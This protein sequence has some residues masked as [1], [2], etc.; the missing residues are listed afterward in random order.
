MGKDGFNLAAGR[1]G[2]TE[3]G[4]AGSRAS[5]HGPLLACALAASLVLRVAFSFGYWTGKPLT[6]DEQE[7]LLLAESLAGGRGFHYPDPQEGAAAKRFERPPGFP[8]ALAAVLVGTRAAVPDSWLAGRELA[9]WLTQDSSSVPPSIRLGQA[10]LGSLVVLLIAGLARRAAGRVAGVAAAW[11][12]AVYPPLVWVCA[13]VLSEPLYSVLA[14]STALLLA[15]ATSNDVRR[16]RLVAFVAGLAAALAVLT[17]EAMLL[18]LPLAFIWLL[19]RRKLAL[20]ALLAA[21]AVCGLAPWA[22]RNFAADR[23]FRLSAARGGINFWIGN[24]PLA[25][26]EGDMAANPE[27]K[28]ASLALEAAHPGASPA[29]MD[30]VYYREAFDYIAREPVSW[31]KL[32]GRKLFYTVVPAGPS[33]TLRSP[34]YMYASVASYGLLFIAA[35]PGAAWL[36]RK[37]RG[38]WSLWILG[39]SAVLT[40]LVFFPQER[41]RIPVIDPVLIVCAS[42]WMAAWAERRLR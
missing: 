7:Y 16:P 27:V 37:R 5:W 14:L 18:F 29:E 42:A 13:Y 23:T 8:V 34:R 26:G 19:W 40:N 28:R 41:F 20:A 33:Y 3:T 39:A 12:A 10:F 36:A 31:A 11:L 22:A 38:P 25:R 15:A 6:W 17:R 30:R 24:N 35:I 1:P 32:L 4:S 9:S 2:V 21:G